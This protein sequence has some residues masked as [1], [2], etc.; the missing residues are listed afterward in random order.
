MSG[1]FAT[2]KM[3]LLTSQKKTHT[4]AENFLNMHEH[5]FADGQAIPGIYLITDISFQRHTKNNARSKMNGLSKYTLYTPD[6][7]PKYFSRSTFS[8]HLK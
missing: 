4:H 5:I 7:D 1:F 6:S 3:D 8:P 2:Y